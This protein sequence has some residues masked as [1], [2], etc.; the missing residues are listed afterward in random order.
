MVSLDHRV[1]RSMALNLRGK[2]GV[3]SASSEL[4]RRRLGGLSFFRRRKWCY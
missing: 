4:V 3:S 2:C 1:T